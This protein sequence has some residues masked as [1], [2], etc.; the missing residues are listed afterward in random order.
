MERR[1]GIGGRREGGEVE[2]VEGESK[3]EKEMER[4]REEGRDEIQHCMVT[5]KHL[6]GK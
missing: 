4:K 5:D 6:M 3:G 1:G 2:G